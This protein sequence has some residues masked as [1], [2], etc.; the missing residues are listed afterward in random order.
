[1][2]LDQSTPYTQ[3]P[4]FHYILWYLIGLLP[5]RFGSH[6]HTVL[7]VC[8]FLVPFLG[9]V[10]VDQRAMVVYAYLFFSNLCEREKS[11]PSIIMKNC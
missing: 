4:P 10:Y 3:S 8:L 1:M 5:A 6:L 7:L 9:Q 11:Q 2:V